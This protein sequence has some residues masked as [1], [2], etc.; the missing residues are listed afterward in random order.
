MDA[1][2]TQVQ[3]LATEADEAGRMEILKALRDLQYRVETPKDTFMRFYNAVSLYVLL[4]SFFKKYH[5][6]HIIAFFTSGDD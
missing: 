2:I 1:I 3:A 4:F 6:S 5:A